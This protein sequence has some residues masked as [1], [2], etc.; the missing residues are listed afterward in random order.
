MSIP[1]K[2]TTAEIFRW[3]VGQSGED[4]AQKFE[5]RETT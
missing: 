4:I 5:D 3:R 2:K 1:W